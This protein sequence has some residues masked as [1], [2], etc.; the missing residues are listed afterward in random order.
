MFLPKAVM[1]HD[2]ATSLRRLRHFLLVLSLLAAGT[3]FTMTGSK[4]EAAERCPLG[5]GWGSME[6]VASAVPGITDFELFRFADLDG[7]GD[8]DRLLLDVIGGVRE[9]RND[10]GGR[11]AYRGRIALGT[12]YP[13]ERVKFADLNG[14]GKDDYLVVKNDGALDAWIN[15]GG[16]L[17]GPEGITP[18][19]RGVGQI[20]RGTGASPHQIY[21]GDLDGDGD[22]DYVSESS[23]TGRVSAWRNDGG[24]RPGYDGWT[25]WSGN[26]PTNGGSE[27]R[28]EFADVNCD[29]L[30]DLTHLSP[31]SALFTFVN[32]GRQ[33]S[34]WASYPS[35]TSESSDDPSNR[36]RIAELNGDGK[37]DYLL[38]TGEGMLLGRLN[39][40]GD[41]S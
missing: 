23:S 22:D 19:W 28:R 20:A 7:D 8:D 40:G 24:D 17:T 36:V 35:L 29:G 30:E 38:M 15:E 11:W 3:T 9:W 39:K 18:R 25:S 34:S 10:R 31:Q 27:M 33:D 32:L 13:P 5:G 26:L 6:V 1:A 21:F 14:D 4:A 37:V 41:A 16:D 2:G 12:G